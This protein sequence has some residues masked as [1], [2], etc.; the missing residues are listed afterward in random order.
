MDI[1]SGDGALVFATSLLFGGDI[2][3]SRGVE[4]VPTLFERSQSHK[5]TF[6]EVLENNKVEFHCGDI[7]DCDDTMENILA[8]T[9][10]AICFATTWSR[11]NQGRELPQLSVSLG[12]FLTSGTKV[13]VV[14]GKLDE[15]DGLMW[16]GDLQISCPDTVPYSI[17]SLYQKS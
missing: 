5:S 6:A 15:K 9:S 4:I 2:S 7:Y 13:V 12:E 16:Q 8:D 11:G 1:G 10:L 14:D 3:I 17:A